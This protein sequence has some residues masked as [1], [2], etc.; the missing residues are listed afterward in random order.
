MVTG[1]VPHVGGPIVGPGAPNVL[2]NVKP[3]ALMGDMCVCTGPPDTIAQGEPTVLINGTPVATLG[4]MTAHGG[5]VV[6]GEPTVMVGSATPGAKATMPLK[7]IPFPEIR[8]YD[9]AGAAAR[10]K[11]SDLKEAEA[12]QEQI[13]QDAVEQKPMIVSNL[14]WQ[15]EENIIENSLVNDEVTLCADASGIDEERYI[16]FKIYEKDEDNGDNLI[17]SQ[18]GKVQDGKIEISWAVKCFEDGED[19]QSV[20]EMQQKAY[21]LP[22]IVFKYDNSDG[23]TVESGILTVE[24]SLVIKAVDKET[25]EVLSNYDYMILLPNGEMLEGQ[26]DEEGYVKLDKI[27]PSENYPIVISKESNIVTIARE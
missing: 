3:A 17:G 24:D 1:T 2:I 15:K 21:T 11:S 22:E 4:S 27:R 26:L 14:R 8:F 7:K 25:G 13:R 12:N 6:M 5:S 19:S 9:K 10:G 18:S 16:A 23:E 20:E